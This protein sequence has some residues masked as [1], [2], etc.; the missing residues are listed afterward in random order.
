MTND[1]VAI[2]NWRCPYCDQPQVVMSA[3]AEYEYIN[4]KTARSKVGPFGVELAAITCAN[5]ECKQL[6]LHATA[7]EEKGPPGASKRYRINYWRLLPKGG[8][9]KPLHS[10]VPEPI[11]RDFDEACSIVSLSPK[12][13]ATLLRRC[14]QGMIRD[15]CGVT[16]KPTLN[17]EIKEL[18]ARRDAGNLPEGVPPGTIN[19]LHDLRD[20]GNIGAHMERDINVIIDID[21]GEAELL[22]A[23]VEMLAAD[24]YVARHDRRSRL[25][26]LSKAV[27]EKKGAKAGDNGGLS[28]AG[29]G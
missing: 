28:G 2:K 24:W 8:S 25:E 17:A 15:F 16:N 6:A 22:I 1:S 4:F 10:C 5:S 18:E 27:A 13:S 23:H 26:A 14:M 29:E 9:R 7:F 19:G 12:A 21:E 11:R 20:L 3:N